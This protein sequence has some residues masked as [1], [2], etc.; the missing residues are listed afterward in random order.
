MMNTGMNMD[1]GYAHMKKMNSSW[2]DWY[3]NDLS[4]THLVLTV[5][6]VF[7]SSGQK[8]NLPR[9]SSFYKNKV[10]WKLDKQISRRK[11]KSVIYGDDFKYEF[12]E[13]SKYKGVGD[14]RSPHHI[15]G[16]I[17]V[18]HQHA[19]KIW[20]DEMDS[21]TERLK[22]DLKSVKE[23][24]TIMIERIRGSSLSWITYINK[25]KLNYLH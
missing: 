13:K 1:M 23:I 2:S 6:V 8:P 18:P 16:I 17:C 4:Q 14:L 15:H 20:N 22:K 10:L 5:T 25:G 3:D 12:L 11:V 19:E 21:V 24:S 9:W 7:K